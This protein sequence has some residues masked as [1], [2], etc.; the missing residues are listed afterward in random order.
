MEEQW[1][2]QTRNVEGT[3]FAHAVV[4]QGA[5]SADYEALQDSL[6][7][8]LVFAA[9]QQCIEPNLPF[10]V[11]LTAKL[12]V[13]NGQGEEKIKHIQHKFNINTNGVD[14]PPRRIV[15]GNVRQFTGFLTDQIMYRVAQLLEWQYDVAP[16]ALSEI[17]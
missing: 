12:K 5:V 1:D 11:S 3:F 14:D 2:V 8:P 6:E 4:L 13:Q 17:K 10:I 7:H 9:L 15:I 16:D